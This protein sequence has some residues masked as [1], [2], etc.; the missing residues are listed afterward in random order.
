MKVIKIA[1]G[2][3]DE[4][5]YIAYKEGSDK[6]F[7][8][9]PGG[10]ASLIL[11]QLDENGIEDVTHILLTHG[12]FDHIGAAAEL[13][14]ATGAK[15]CVHARDAHMLKSSKDCLA[16][17]A[18]MRIQ[19]CEADV[20]LHGGETLKA[21]DIDVHV[22]HTPG[23]SGGSVCYIAEDVMFSGDTL[24]YM[25]GGRTDLPGGDPAEYFETLNNI[26]RPIK[27]DN[28][29]YTGHGPGTTLL[30]EFRHKFFKRPR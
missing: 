5:A 3:L 7:V 10:D 24:F 14:R 16:V 29:V 26:I 17:M 25:A 12:H 6:A 2:G 23:H 19:P 4:N 13:R 1:V 8:V 11:A 9:D 27:N 18:G 20:I 15:V 30:G 21:A 22:L 28:T